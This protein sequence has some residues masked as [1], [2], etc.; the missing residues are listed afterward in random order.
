M[1]LFAATS[2]VLPRA[3][4]TRKVAIHHPGEMERYVYTFSKLNVHVFQLISPAGFDKVNPTRPTP[5]P[6]VPVR[7]ATLTTCWGSRVE[8]LGAT[9]SPIQTPASCR[10]DHTSHAHGSATCRAS[11]ARTAHHRNGQRQQLSSVENP[12]LTFTFAAAA[13]TMTD[14]FRHPC[15]LAVC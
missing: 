14:P 4:R 3:A 13:A 6:C 9:D 10:S 15:C 12:D 2:R 5:A 7:S 8:I 11:G 1:S